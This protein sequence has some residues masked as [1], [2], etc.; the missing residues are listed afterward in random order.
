M[1]LLRIL[2]NGAR[3][4][5]RLEAANVKVRKLACT[6]Q[7]DAEVISLGRIDGPELLFVEGSIYGQ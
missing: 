7:Q 6:S 5:G 1:R 2:D 3:R 4:S